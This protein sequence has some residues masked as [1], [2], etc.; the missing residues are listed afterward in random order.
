M[1]TANKWHSLGSVSISNKGV[2]EFPPLPNLPAESILT[3]K[4]IPGVYR[5]T[6]NNGHIY[7]G[8][9]K[10]LRL[11]FGNYRSPTSGTEQEHVVRY[12]LLDAGGATVEVIP[13]SSLVTRHALE[14]A[15]QTAAIKAGLP[16]LNTGGRSRGHYL[17]FKV[18]YHEDMLAK[19]RAELENS[20]TGA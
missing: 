1:P 6:F 2:P 8:K 5:L 7:I 3:A 15:E 18:K 19:S 12:I 11:R 9:A 13:E 10:N 16:L 20:N 17:K 14:R 4:S